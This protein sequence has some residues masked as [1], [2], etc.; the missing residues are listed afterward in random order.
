[1]G[2]TD[3]SLRYPLQVIFYRCGQ[4]RMKKWS[5]GKN[6]IEK[7]LEKNMH[8]P[9]ARIQH[10]RMEWQMFENNSDKRR[11]NGFWVKVWLFDFNPQM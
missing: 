6:V 4:N 1:M 8:Q 11:M 9:D 10:S 2:Q 7:N 3:K 5:H